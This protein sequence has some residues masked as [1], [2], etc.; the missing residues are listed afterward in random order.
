MSEEEEGGEARLRGG[1]GSARS[2][3]RGPCMCAPIRAC[4]RPC[5]RTCVRVRVRV[6]RVQGVISAGAGLTEAAVLR[7]R[8]SCPQ[9]ECMCAQMEAGW[10]GSRG[11]VAAQVVL[12]IKALSLWTIAQTL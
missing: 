10:R 7:Q 3:E 8:D 6:V 1:V 2:A 5:V 11:Q 9:A 12:Y 4:V